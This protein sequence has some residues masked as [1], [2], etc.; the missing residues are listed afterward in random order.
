MERSGSSSSSEFEEEL[1]NACAVLVELKEYPSRYEMYVRMTK[2]EFQFLHALIK[3]NIVTKN[4]QMREAVITEEKLAVCLGKDQ[5]GA[6]YSLLIGSFARSRVYT[7]VPDEH[8]AADAVKVGRGENDV[9]L[10]VELFLATGNSFRS[11]GFS[12]AGNIR[13]HPYAVALQESEA[14]YAPLTER[15]IEPLYGIVWQ[16]AAV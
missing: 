14:S 16:L 9:S 6:K 11:L 5:V 7:P 2:E 3:E 12:T 1:E 13:G 8:E 15:R 10:D 4:T